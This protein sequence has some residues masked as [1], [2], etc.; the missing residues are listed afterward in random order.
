MNVWGIPDWL[1]KEVMEQDKQCVYCGIEMTEKMRPHGPRKAVATWEHI[2][3]D[4]WIVN[5]ANIARCCAACN[6]SKGAKNLSDWLQSRYCITRGINK[7]TV[8]EVVEKGAAAGN[9]ERRPIS[10][11]ALGP[12]VN[13]AIRRHQ[14]C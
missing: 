9:S 5:R 8:S 14:S 12:R 13:R 1:E 7:D 11:C 4:A 2:M 10:R 6:S 3:N